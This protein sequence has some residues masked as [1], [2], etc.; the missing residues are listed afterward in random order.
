MY[1]QCK[2]CDQ[3]EDSEHSVFC[4]YKGNVNGG[5]GYGDWDSKHSETLRMAPPVP[6]DM[7]LF[8]PACG[9]QHIDAAESHEADEN[10]P[11]RPGGL[12]NNPPHKTH[13]CH[14]CGHKWRPA[15]VPTNGVAA[16]KTRG[17]NDNPIVQQ[18]A[19]VL[20]VASDLPANDTIIART[21]SFGSDEEAMAALISAESAHAQP[22]LEAF[23]KFKDAI[24][25]LTI[26]VSR[27]AEDKH[28]GDGA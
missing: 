15:D 9:T 17:A 3:L 16:V 7:V 21:D 11:Q 20:R 2:F 8:C 23:V 18:T 28:R 14:S 10:E 4:R 22:Y 19:R 6:I 1:R 26:A 5:E 12:W 24:E 27:L 25:Y 13:L